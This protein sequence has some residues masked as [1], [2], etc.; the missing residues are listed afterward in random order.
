MYLLLWGYVRIGVCT[1]GDACLLGGSTGTV[2]FIP[3]YALPLP[4]SSSLPLLSVWLSPLDDDAPIK[5]LTK[6]YKAEP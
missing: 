1:C 6:K 2:K 5:Y 3:S 4:S